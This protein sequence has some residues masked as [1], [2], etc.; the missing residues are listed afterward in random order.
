[1]SKLITLACALLAIGLGVWS[2]VSAHQ[3]GATLDEAQA[4][5]AGTV[6]SPPTSPA[7]VPSDAV[8]ADAVLRPSGSDTAGSSEAPPPAVLPAPIYV[9]PAVRDRQDNGDEAANQSQPLLPNAILPKRT[10]PAPTQASQSTM[11]Y[12]LP[13]AGPA[14][15][16]TSPS[17]P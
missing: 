7:G 11:G 16:P 2:L 10:R 9:Q 8:Q 14:P 15:S 1:M 6:R 17:P 12:T 5:N 3:A 4:L 13:Q